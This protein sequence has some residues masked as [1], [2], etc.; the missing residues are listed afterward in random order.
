MQSHS[1]GNIISKKNYLSSFSCEKAT[2]LHQTECRIQISPLELQPLVVAPCST[3]PCAWCIWC[4]GNIWLSRGNDNRCT[5]PM[6]GDGYP[7]DKQIAVKEL[8]PILVA[9]ILW[10]SEWR[11]K[12]VLSYCDNSAVV[13]VLNSRYS[14]D[15]DL[16]QLL[17][18]LFFLEAQLQFQL[19]GSHIPGAANSCADNLSRNQ[20][21]AF[22]ISTP[23]ADIYPT[24]IPS[25][26]LQWLLLP[27]MDWTSPT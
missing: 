25:S 13:S 7:P 16:M 5:I 15:K 17:R 12:R 1:A 6:G 2:L 10:G 18:C 20:L 14:R 24:P 21:A 9:I 3:T 4:N 22:R 23:H 19:S 26:L 8:I 11:E 27:C